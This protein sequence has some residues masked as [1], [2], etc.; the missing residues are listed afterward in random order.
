MC[1]FK[2]FRNFFYFDWFLCLNK[3]K[4][5]T[6]D[7]PNSFYRKWCEIQQYSF[8]LDQFI[9]LSSE[10]SPRLRFPI[11]G[12]YHLKHKYLFTSTVVVS[13]DL[14]FA[15]SINC[16]GYIRHFCL[17]TNFHVADSIP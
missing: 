11:R 5:I 13:V 9:D 8:H 3:F 12:R 7:K 1:Y 10:E 17:S 6:V 2:A 4:F 14:P 16:K 15:N